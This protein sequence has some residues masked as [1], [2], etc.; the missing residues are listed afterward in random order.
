G[1]KILSKPQ[2]NKKNKKKNKVLFKPVLAAVFV[3]GLGTAGLTGLN[4]VTEKASA[5]DTY[6]RAQAA[7]DVQVIVDRFTIT[8]FCGQDSWSVRKG[9]EISR[10]RF[11]ASNLVTM[12]QFRQMRLHA[13][14][15]AEDYLAATGPADFN[16]WCS[17]NSEK[18]TQFFLGLMSGNKTTYDTTYK[19]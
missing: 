8:E 12:K 1:Q 14:K 4:L 11:L 6:T 3:L 5:S 10:K 7:R 19:P 15:K 13:I 9:Y 17:K 2:K 18:A 16:R